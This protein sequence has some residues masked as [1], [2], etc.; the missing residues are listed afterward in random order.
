MTGVCGGPIG[1]QIISVVLLIGVVFYW[2]YVFSKTLFTMWFGHLPLLAA[3]CV[4]T[5]A[6]LIMGWTTP[7]GFYCG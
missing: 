2:R 6:F 4:A 3:M 1:S 7:T 5:L